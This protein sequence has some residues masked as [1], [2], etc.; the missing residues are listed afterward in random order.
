MPPSLT[1]LFEKR[2]KQEG[3]PSPVAEAVKPPEVVTKPPEVVKPPEQQKPDDKE[4]NFARLREAKEK[5][6]ADHKAAQE[7][8]AQLE[9]D[10]ETFKSRPAPED[11]EKQKS[12]YEA[13][14]EGITKELRAAAV[15]RDP[16][17]QK[18]YDSAISQKQLRLVSLLTEGGMSDAEARQHVRAWNTVKFSEVAET[19][20]WVQQQEFGKLISDTQALANERQ[21]EIDAGESRWNELQE[22][23]T[24]AQKE[25]QEK[26]RKSFQGDAEEVYKTLTQ[27]PAIAADPELTASI[28]A[29]IN[30]ATQLHSD[31]FSRKDILQRVGLS[32][33]LMKVAS[34]QQ[35]ELE[36]LR[37]QLAE[38]D[39]K[40]EEQEKFLSEHKTS[41]PR[42]GESNGVKTGEGTSKVPFYKNIRVV[43]PGR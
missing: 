11:V 10:L 16:D 34:A 23:R 13:R 18:K 26:F 22:T 2:N 12:E 7:R 43:L 20:P 42:P 5:V 31:A 39:K 14:L 9:K 27:E 35:S 25:Q 30:R 41:I 19:L 4:I 8:L 3:K 29:D 37:T 21:V 6:E 36:T 32:T 17:F 40:I 38:R 33:V 15:W 1:A 24:K 28:Q